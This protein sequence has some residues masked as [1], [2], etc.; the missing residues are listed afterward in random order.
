MDLPEVGWVD[1]EDAETGGKLLVDTT[2]SEARLRVRIAAEEV[3][4][5]RARALT[6]AGVDHLA[7][8]TDQSYEKPMHET[9]ARRA[10]RFKR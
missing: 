9:F 2:D 7:L 10:R 3:R 8:R 5:N 6:N 1:L 4:I